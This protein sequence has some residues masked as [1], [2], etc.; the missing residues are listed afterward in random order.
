MRIPT[1]IFKTLAPHHCKGGG[2]HL[3][4][5]KND[6]QHNVGKIRLNSSDIKFMKEFLIMK[7]PLKV[8]SP[9]SSKTDRYKIWAIF[10]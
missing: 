4:H 1:Q 9:I 6:V 10:L 8:D 7:A 5:S 2:G 3:V